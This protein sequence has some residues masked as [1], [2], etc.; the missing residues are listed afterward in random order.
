[1][2][3][4]KLILLAC[5]LFHAS[6]IYDVTPSLNDSYGLVLPSETHWWG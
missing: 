6:P 5:G 4:G 3:D 2:S 1:M